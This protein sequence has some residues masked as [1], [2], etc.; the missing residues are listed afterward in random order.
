MSV[1][2]DIALA[3]AARAANI[4]IANGF[5]TD[6]GLKVLRGR[7]RLDKTHLPCVVVIERDDQV[8]DTRNASVKLSQPFVIEG[9]MVCDPDN[10]NDTAHKI[11]ADIKQVMF[12][13]R[14]T[15][16]AD[17]RL[18]PIKYVGRSIAVREDG[19]EVVSAAVEI[20]V[21]YVDA[22]ATP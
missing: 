14:L 2:N 3:V 16:G 20:A 19:I 5:E 12:G 6:I 17:Q 13:D 21:E 4:Q 18:L 11:I 7:R 15:Y 9:H 1:A 8:L 10:P 22:L